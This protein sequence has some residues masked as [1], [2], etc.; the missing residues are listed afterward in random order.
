[1][2]RVF[3]GSGSSYLRVSALCPCRGI[4]GRGSILHLQ[5]SADSDSMK[6]I[7]TFSDFCHNPRK[8]LVRRRTTAASDDARRPDH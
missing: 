4:P 3:P 2:I 6:E 5:Y 7:V 8:P 1:M